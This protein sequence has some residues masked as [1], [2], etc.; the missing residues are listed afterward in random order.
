[1]HNQTRLLAFIVASG[2]SMAGDGMALVAVPW[3]VLR[4]TGS[5][6][7]CGLIAAAASAAVVLTGLLGGPLTD[8]FGGKKVAVASELMAG[9]SL[10]AIP[11]LYLTTGIG[12]PVL[13]ALA[14]LTAGFQAPGTAARQRSLLALAD[15]T[16]SDRT[17]INGLYWLLQQIGLLA[18]A[19]LAGVIMSLA[20]PP[21][22]LVVDVAT[23]FIAAAVIAAVACDAD[24]ATGGAVNSRR[25]WVAYVA[26]LRQGLGVALRE[27]AIRLIMAC[28]LVLNLFDGALLPL[29]LPVLVRGEDGSPR[30]L[31]V[32]AACYAGGM[33]VGTLGASVLGSRLMQRNVFVYCLAASS[34][35]Y[36]LLSAIP[37]LDLPAVFLLGLAGGPMLPLI[38]SVIQNTVPAAFVGRVLGA[39][40]SVFMA[41]VPLGRV[42]IGCFLDAHNLHW[43]FAA[44]AAAFIT[45]AL[46]LASSSKM[47]AAT[48]P[49]RVTGDA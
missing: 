4:T 16:D 48:F 22:A 28:A 26:D 34:V 12:F 10:A 11:V 20:A 27:P 29:M 37:R 5:I 44:A 45:A 41:S 19:P 40:F 49:N 2:L 18:G 14:A 8:R 33:I 39:L 31:G 24:H 32:L 7:D 30:V 3:F 35:A 46:G 15:S 17:R 23:F 6:L 25:W 1:M 47:L 42:V 13:I 9:I 43:L 21:V 38:I 36:G